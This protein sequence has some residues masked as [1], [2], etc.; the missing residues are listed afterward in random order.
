MKRFT[1]ATTFA[2]AATALALSA[3]ASA[4]PPVQVV[5][6]RSSALSSAQGVESVEADI[7]AAA[8][9][10]CNVRG[11]HGA[12]VR[13]A[14]RECEL[15]ARSDAMRELDTRVAEARQDARSIRIAVRSD[16]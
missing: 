5:E 1:L 4:Q 16:G 2:A 6:F 11:A 7:R 10:V 8:R 14:E 9:E 13:R 3:G 12:D 15:K